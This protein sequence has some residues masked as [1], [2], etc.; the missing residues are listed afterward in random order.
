MNKEQE[1]RCEKADEKLREIMDE[2]AVTLVIDL[3]DGC[4][5]MIPNE[6]MEDRPQLH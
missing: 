4:I 5:S 3:F 1:E 6:L 2:F